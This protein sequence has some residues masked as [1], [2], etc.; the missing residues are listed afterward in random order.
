MLRM[1]VGI[2]RV[3]SCKIDTPR[4]IE[5]IV[6][7]IAPHVIDVIERSDIIISNVSYPSLKYGVLI[8]SIL[9]P[10]MWVGIKTKAGF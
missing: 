2:T 7:T 8:P 4:E 9:T 6:Y 1:P 5:I 10:D 3:R